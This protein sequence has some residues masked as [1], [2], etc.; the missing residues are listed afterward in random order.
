MSELAIDLM[1]EEFIDDYEYF[2]LIRE[3]EWK[4]YMQKKEEEYRKA[5]GNGAMFNLMWKEFL[6]KNGE[7]CQ[8][9]MK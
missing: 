1:N 5:Y 3:A 2:Q 8:E 6:N 4:D 9:M 7:L